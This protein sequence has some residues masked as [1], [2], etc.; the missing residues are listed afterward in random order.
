[1]IEG[2]KQRKELKINEIKTEE[3][4]PEMILGI[5][6]KIKDENIVIDDSK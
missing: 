3:K 4:E 5:V 2:Y 1:M 6:E